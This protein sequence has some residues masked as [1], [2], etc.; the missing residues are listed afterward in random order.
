MRKLVYLGVFVALSFLL[1]ESTA[2]ADGAQLIADLNPGSAGSFPSNLTVH[3][4]AL[5]FSAY[6][7]TTGRELWKCD[8]TNITMV[9]NIHAD[10]GTNYSSYPNNLFA[11]NGGLY[12]MADNGENGYELWKHD[13]VKTTLNDINPGGEGSSSYPKNFTPFKNELVFVATRD[14]V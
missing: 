10:L 2:A 5:F 4:N 13:G 7:L 1:A 9:T 3:A 8:G 12:F 6:T 11:W 14:D